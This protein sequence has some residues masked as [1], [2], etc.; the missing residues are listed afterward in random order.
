MREPSVLVRIAGVLESSFESAFSKTEKQLSKVQ[1]KIASLE[2]TSKALTSFQSLSAMSEKAKLS[3]LGKE[4]ALKKLSE[5]IKKVGVATEPQSQRMTSLAQSIELTKTKLE[6]QTKSLE[7]YK[8]SIKEAGLSTANFSTHQAHLADSIGNLKSQE[9]QLLSKRKDNFKLQDAKWKYNSAQSNFRNSALRTGIGTAALFASPIQ[10]QH[11]MTRLM[12]A[13]KDRSLPDTKELEDENTKI[14]EKMVLGVS[15]K[16]PF[17]PVTVAREAA[18]LGQAGFSIKDLQAN[19][20]SIF[21]VSLATDAVPAEIA[22]IMR[23]LKSSFQLDAGSAE[24]MNMLAN[25][26]AKTVN[27]TAMRVD[28]ISQSVSYLTDLP[29]AVGMNL[30]D[31]LAAMGALKDRGINRSIIGTS[32][33]AFFNRIAKPKI[34]RKL[35][36]KNIK[37]VEIKDGK[38]IFRPILSIVEDIAKAMKPLGNAD[39]QA[40]LTNTFET[41]AGRSVGA[42]IEDI[43]DPNGKLRDFV[44]SLKYVKKPMLGEKHLELDYLDKMADDLRKSYWNTMVQTGSTAIVT[45]TKIFESIRPELTSITKSMGELLGSFNNF[46]DAHPIITKAATMITFGFLGL[47]LALKGLAVIKFAAIVTSLG[48]LGALASSGIVLGLS[49]L[50]AAGYFIWQNWDKVSQVLDRVHQKLE[51]FSKMKPKE[52]MNLIFPPQEQLKLNLP[53][54]LP[55][56]SSEDNRSYQFSFE[57]PET[58]DPQSYASAVREKLIGAQSVLRPKPRS[59]FDLSE[60]F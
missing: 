46:V 26:I 1:Q 23:S 38:R 57:L 49:A 35:A 37:V 3:L 34:Q 2:N 55:Q 28:D 14:L 54:Y 12:A 47:S 8:K 50:G 21:K 11:E 43:N 48:G 18:E 16:L 53:N 19:L 32:L 9:L 25:S 42:L 29:K 41:E 39:Q 24:Q 5:T 59:F 6:A 31:T 17:T 60:S 44:K 27:M 51:T 56:G 15:S 58:K 10:Y 52:L 45:S 33:V 22:A 30:G 4:N 20:P 7:T 40:F 36:A 13:T